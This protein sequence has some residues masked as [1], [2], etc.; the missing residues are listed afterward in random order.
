MIPRFSFYRN[1]VEHFSYDYNCEEDEIEV[2]DTKAKMSGDYYT[3][4]GFGFKA[5]YR[6]TKVACE[7]AKRVW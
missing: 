1:L 3:L 4:E 6:C 2:L 5:V 7:E